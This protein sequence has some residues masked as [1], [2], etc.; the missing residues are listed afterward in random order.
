MKAWR[1]TS[2]SP[3]SPTA[4]P[5]VI[6]VTGV[7]DLGISQMEW[8]FSTN[9]SSVSNIAP[10]K[11]NGISPTANLGIAANTVTLQYLAAASGDTWSVADATGI[12][13]VGG[14]ILA[15]PESGTV[16]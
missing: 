11:V 1:R 15:V 14:G 9:I 4:S 3:S 13:F 10:F 2:R 6:T 8:N 7:F 16:V 5:P 12:A